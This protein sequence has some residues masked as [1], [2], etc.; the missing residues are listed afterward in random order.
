MELLL[1]DCAGSVAPAAELCSAL[2]IA[3]GMVETL[4]RAAGAEEARARS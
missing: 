3:V 2:C 4:V 1:R